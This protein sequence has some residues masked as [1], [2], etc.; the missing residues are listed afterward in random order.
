MFFKV[1]MFIHLSKLNQEI[2]G[3]AHVAHTQMAI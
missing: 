1:P 2:P 3:T